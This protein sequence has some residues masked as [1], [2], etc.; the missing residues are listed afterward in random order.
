MPKVADDLGRRGIALDLLGFGKSDKRDDMAYSAR[1]H[2]D[3]VEAFIEKLDLKSPLLVLHD[4][5]GPLG[6]AYAINHPNNV[7]GLA[8]METFVWPFA[9]K[10]LGRF[11][12]M[13]WLFRS[14]LGY[15]LLQVMNVFVNNIL[16]RSVM[17]K[18]NMSREVMR[19]YR[20]PFPSTR[21]RKAI[22]AFTKLLPIAGHPAKSD[23]FIE[24]VQKRLQGVKF[25]LLWIKATP[26][27]IVSKETEYHLH[28]LQNMLPQLIIKDFGAG[29][30]CLQ[31][32]D[33]QKIA[34]LITEWVHQCKRTNADT[35]PS[36]PI[37]VNLAA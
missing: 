24:D 7:W 33:P 30:H 5:G 26:G 9:W 12:P 14:P 27:A 34:N 36:H 31:E 32:D 19:H 21:S 23:D 20:E 13:C 8:F 37:S 1:L 4:W 15:I 29:F 35:A 10:D 18:E 17:D 28:L 2:A 3:I 6:A 25:P 22:R 11:A 16:P